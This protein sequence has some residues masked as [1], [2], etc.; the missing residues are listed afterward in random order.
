MRK[1]LV[2]TVLT[3]LFVA[4]LVIAAPALAA[5]ELT[6]DAD[7]TID[8]SNPDTNLTILN[9]SIVDSMTVNAGSID[10]VLTLCESQ[11]GWRIILPFW[12]LFWLI[13]LH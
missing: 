3:L 12:S 13:L 10:F 8:L 4:P 2:T 7:T 6:F 9:N 5:N 11:M 1:T